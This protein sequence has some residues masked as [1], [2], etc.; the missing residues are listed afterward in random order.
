MDNGGKK[1]ERGY[2]A[3]RGAKDGNKNNKW[4]QTHIGDCAADR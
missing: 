2:P 3:P 4:Q 1:G